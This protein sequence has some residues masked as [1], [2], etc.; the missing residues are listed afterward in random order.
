MG[1]AR[2]ALEEENE[3]YVCVRWNE[4]EKKWNK[5]E[6]W[7]EIIESESPP[8]DK[9]VRL[10]NVDPKGQFRMLDKSEKQKIAELQQVAWKVSR[11]LRSEEVKG[12]HTGPPESGGTWILFSL[13]LTGVPVWVIWGRVPFIGCC[14]WIATL[15]ALVIMFTPEKKGD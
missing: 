4:W 8:A 3:K 10:A 6:E 7:W 12:Y 9:E 15:C 5:A 13:L 1:N 2:R 14:G 11:R